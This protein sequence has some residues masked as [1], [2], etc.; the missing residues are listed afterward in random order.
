MSRNKMALTAAAG[1]FLFAFHLSAQ[2]DNPPPAQTGVLPPTY[3]ENF[4]L[5]TN[6]I[7]VR[8]FSLAGS[9]VLGNYTLVVH[10]NEVNDMTHSQKAYGVVM[11]LRL[12]NSDADTQV[13]WV[14]DYDELDSLANALDYISKVT[15]GVTQLNGF[16]AT[17]KTKS[18]FRLVAHSDRK[19]QTVATSIQFGDSPRIPASSDQLLQIRSLISQ[20][21]ATLD[22]L[23]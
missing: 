14:M 17:Y 4:E 10:A 3:L 8:G 5:Q 16:E 11:N 12:S 22:A 20:A 19:D 15:W 2:T 23:K 18:G 21:K 6:T 7:L 1:L 9:V 13:E